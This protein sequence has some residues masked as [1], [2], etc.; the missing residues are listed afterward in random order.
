MSPPE[1]MARA[2][3]RVLEHVPPMM[4]D[5]GTPA[6]GS[7]LSLF[8]SWELWFISDESLEIW[9]EVWEKVSSGGAA[10]IFIA[11]RAKISPNGYFSRWMIDACHGDKCGRPGDGTP[12]SIS[13]FPT[14]ENL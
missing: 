11:I 8:L 4:L 10:R 9:G 5:G 14:P 3:R 1:D 13:S 12:M 7:C 2:F 6:K